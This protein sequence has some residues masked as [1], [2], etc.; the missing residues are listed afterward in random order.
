VPSP[1]D[2]P[3]GCRFRTRCWKAQ[4]IC[5]AEVPPP[6]PVDGSPTHHATCH[7]PEPLAAVTAVAKAAE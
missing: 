7:F 5:A 3:S 2:P 6:L 1:L 4:P